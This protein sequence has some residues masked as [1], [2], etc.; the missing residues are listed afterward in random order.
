M[1][2]AISPCPNDTFL[3]D[4][5]LHGKIASPITPKATLADIQQL[6]LWALQGVYPVTKISSVCFAKVTNAY[7]LLPVGAA[8]GPFGPKLI[9]KEL[10]DL[11]ELS[12]K[13]VAIPGKETTAYLLFRTLLPEPK[14]VIFCRY[15]EIVPLIASGK[16]DA[17][18]IIHETRF[19]FQTAG[20]FELADLGVLFY[21]R[22]K[23][24]VPLGVVVAKKTVPKKQV[25]EV[26]EAMRASLASAS[27]SDFVLEQ[28]QEKKLD[29]VKQHI[30][31]YVTSETKEISEEGLAAIRV[32][33]ELGA[34]HNLLPADCK[35]FMYHKYFE[36]N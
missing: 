18:L 4:S 15:E 25:A 1:L 2:L 22:Y 9:A 3:F 35:S 32:L 20:Y 29:I 6:N 28:S 14:N 24:P 21:E 8:I 12:T 33:F 16:V 17:G 13:T 34:R 19:T 10:F 27:I 31:M 7:T 11:N 30:E 5:W 26:V 23:L 36:K